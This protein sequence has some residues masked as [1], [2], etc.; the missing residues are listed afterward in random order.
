M[1]MQDLTSSLIRRY[2]NRSIP[3]LT[4]LSATYLYGGPREFGR[5][6]VPDDVR[7]LPVG[8][9]VVLSGYD[10]LRRKVQVADPY[11]PNPLGEEHYYEVDLDRLVSAILLGVLTYDA[12][13]L[14][15]EPR[16]RR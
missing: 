9:F 7:G 13:L 1:R 12:N 4:G 16:K 8:H 15:V 3:I 5:D 11:L 6:C 2:L 10:K 14:I